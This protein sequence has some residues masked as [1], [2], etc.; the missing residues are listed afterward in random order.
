MINWYCFTLLCQ[1][2]HSQQAAIVCKSL[3]SVYTSTCWQPRCRNVLSWNWLLQQTAAAR[4]HLTWL[5][6]VELQLQ[7]QLQRL[8]LQLLLPQ[9]LQPQ[10]RPRHCMTAAT[11]TKVLCVMLQEKQCSTA[12]PDS[13]GATADVTYIMCDTPRQDAAQ[14]VHAY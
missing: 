1:T 9:A 3:S 8:A 12:T 5:V 14:S 2:Q 13:A 6:S 7:L 4:I 11:S 10:E